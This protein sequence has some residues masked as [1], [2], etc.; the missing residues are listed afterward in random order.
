MSE[1]LTEERRAALIKAL[2]KE[3]RGVNADHPAIDAELRRLGA[4]G[5]P[6]AKRATRRVT[7]GE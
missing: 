7:R 3:K 5:Q 2:L 1:E 6:P 4:E